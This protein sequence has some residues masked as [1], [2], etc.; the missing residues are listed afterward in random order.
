MLLAAI[1]LRVTGV[2]VFFENNKAIPIL[3]INIVPSILPELES[4]YHIVRNLA[5]LLGRRDRKCLSNLTQ[6]QG[7]LLNKQ[8]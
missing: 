3:Q 4:F 5:Q 2:N 8:S 6:P 7:K 1:S